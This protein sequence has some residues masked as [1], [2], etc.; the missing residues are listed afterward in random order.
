[1]DPMAAEQQGDEVEDPFEVTP[2]TN[3]ETLNLFIDD[4]WASEVK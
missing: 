1:M 4:Y 3:L 2:D